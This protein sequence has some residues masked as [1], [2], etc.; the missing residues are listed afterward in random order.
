M[1]NLNLPATVTDDTPTHGIDLPGSDILTDHPLSGF[2][3]HQNPVNKNIPGE[4]HYQLTPTIVLEKNPAVFTLALAH[5]IRNPLTNINLAVELLQGKLKTQEKQ[6]MLD[7]VSRSAL[8]INDLIGVLLSNY[9]AK[10]APMETIQINLLLN[11]VLA[12]ISDRLV[13]KNILVNKN[14]TRQDSR[15]HVNKQQI[16]IALINLI[17]NAIDAM[18]DGRGDLKLSTRSIARTCV[19]EIEDNGIGISKKNLKNIFKPYFTDK[20]GGLGLGLSTALT[21]LLSNHAKVKVH[22]EEGK[23][24]QFQLFF[25]RALAIED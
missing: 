22:S 9:E 16:T 14:Y 8:R 25:Q 21:S 5:E 17:I 18:P 11:E 3:N 20:P 7:I 15:I 2:S 10:E 12:L 13:L 4:E 1:K 23:G 24:T 6:A 19:I